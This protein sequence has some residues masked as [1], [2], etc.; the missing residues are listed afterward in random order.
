MAAANRDLLSG[1]ISD[2]C[3]KLDR[4]G[5]EADAHG[6]VRLLDVVDGEPG[7]RRGPLGIEE[8]QQSCQA[9]FGLESAVV[10]QAAGG[11]PAGF[12]VHRLGGAVPSLGGEAEIAGDLRGQGPAHEVACLPAMADVVAGHPAFKVGLAAGGQGQIL[13]L[14]PVQE[15]DGRPQML[16]G[17]RELVVRDLLA[18]AALA[19]PAQEMPCCVPVQDFPALGRR[20]GGDEVLHVPF[21]TD[22]LLVPL[23]Q[24]FGGDEDAA[25]VLDDLAFGELVQGLMGERPPAGAEI[26]Q[27]GGDD[28]LGASASRCRPARCR[29]GC[30]EGT[31]VSGL[32]SRC[33]RRGVRGAA[34]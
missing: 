13:F 7:H 24:D 12:V 33:H 5:A 29:P 25:D 30:R 2:G 17:D 22:H 26:G 11:V 15:M 32:S 6:S 34:A 20:V 3:G 19:E 8:Q 14:E 27:D 18:A 23:G 9:V 1:Q 4:N 16:A 28:A 31:A 21:E 10:Q